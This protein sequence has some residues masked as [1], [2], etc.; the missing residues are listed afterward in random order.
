MSTTRAT[1]QPE[2]NASF[3]W[4]LATPPGPGAIAIFNLR[5]DVAPVLERLT[6]H[7]DWPVGIAR[8]VTFEAI[9]DGLAARVDV[10]TFQLMPHGGPRVIQRLGARLAALG[11]RRH[12]R[13]DPRSL[14]P[15]ATSHVEACMLDALARAQSPL[16]IDLLLDQPRRWRVQ[17]P[18]ADDAALA[19]WRR[20]DRLVTP[21]VVVLAGPP[22]VG[23]STLG[24]RLLGR[25]MSIEA[26]LPGTTRDYVGARVELAGLVVDL[27]DT[28]GLR[29]TD[30][31]IEQR[32][33][34]VAEHLIG[35]ADLLVAMTDHERPWP[36]LPRPPDLSV[37]SKADLGARGDADLGVSA[38]TGAGIAELVRRVRDALV[39][40]E[41]LAAPGPWRFDARLAV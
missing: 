2:A 35:R 4:S 1:P 16:A 29:A 9:D 26:D 30:D 3:A 22:N 7:G 8:A 10:D 36:G 34:D 19:R 39:W 5:G 40:P 37:A 21:P 33:I 20:L 41:D 38:V 12:D 25:A 6:G 31:T 18:V 23:K 13:D 24:N 11:G 15:E 17:P 32:A 27:Y 14:Y 28:P